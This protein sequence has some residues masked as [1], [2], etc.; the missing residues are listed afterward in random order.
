MN[1]LKEHGIDIPT[2]IN[3]V[4]EKFTTETNID[5]ND[6]VLYNPDT[7]KISK[8]QTLNF[9]KS[10]MDI[11][12]YN[13][14]N[15]PRSSVMNLTGYNNSLLFTIC[16]LQDN[17]NS[18]NS[19]FYTY[20]MKLSNNGDILKCLAKVVYAYGNIDSFAYCWLTD[21]VFVEINS[22]NYGNIYI[23]TYDTSTNTLVSLKSYNTTKSRKNNLGKPIIKRIDDRHII[24]SLCS[25]EGSYYATQ[26]F[27]ITF[28][29]TFAVVNTQNVTIGDPNS[30]NPFVQSNIIVNGTSGATVYFNQ[31]NS[32]PCYFSDVSFTLSSTVT[33]NLK[34]TTIAP[35]AS[36]PSGGSFFAVNNKLIRIA[37]ALISYSQ[38]GSIL[39]KLKSPS[40]SINCVACDVANTSF[41]V[42]SNNGGNSVI[43]N[44][45]VDS[46]GYISEYIPIFCDNSV[47]GYVLGAIK[48]NNGMF[49]IIYAVLDSSYAYLKAKVLIPKGFYNIIGISK[50]IKTSG[51][52]C[53]IIVDGI[54]SGYS[55][56]NPGSAY[57]CGKS[58]ILTKNNDLY[59][60]GKAVSDKEFLLS[61]EQGLGVR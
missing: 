38:Y 49:L 32:S 47:N 9:I 46:N 53:N 35:I 51:Q 57:Y 56:L 1:L 29:N 20:A 11:S 23:Y 24:L 4:V 54:V 34:A 14:Y 42:S 41:T 16:S 39:S 36:I 45:F 60:M 40:I 13:S 37:E 19:Q 17:Q 8:L 52:L 55:N 59:T 58:S 2:S 30:S 48:L 10:Q 27:V 7:Q 22:D 44:Y 61:I 5:K 6:I 26:C 12:S 18:S 50:E 28:D 21:D 43:C 3:N 25:Y 31:T 33:T 15:F